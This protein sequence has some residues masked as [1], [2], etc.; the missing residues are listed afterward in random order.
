MCGR[1]TPYYYPMPDHNTKVCVKCYP[2]FHDVD[3]EYL[4]KDENENKKKTYLLFMF[5]RKTS[6][7]LYLCLGENLL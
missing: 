6:N 4:L 3:M 2:S 5:M 7:I 1:K